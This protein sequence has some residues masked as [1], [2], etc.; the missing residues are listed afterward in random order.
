[1]S[2]VF[3]VKTSGD[4]LK[5][6]QNLDLSLRKAV[7]MGM[8]TESNALKEALREDTLAGGLGARFGKTWQNKDRAG[9]ILVF[10]SRPGVYSMSAAT[11]VYSKAPKLARAFDEGTVIR[12]KKG[13]G[14][15]VL[16]IPTKDVPKSGKGGRR[17]TPLEYQV[18]F[19]W[20]TLEPVFRDGKPVALV[21]QNAR[22]SYSA[23]TKAF[24]GFRFYDQGKK[25][26]QRQASVILYTLVPA[27]RLK[28]RLH[29]ETT[30]RRIAR[31]LPY[32]IRNIRRSL[33]RG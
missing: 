29:I 12:V 31:R 8:R 1:M 22:A 3:S 18:R 30:F 16:A 10:P 7:T 32:T 27:A 14:R 5:K 15:S 26:V 23:K 25:K 20:D 2:L 6:M 19:G 17:L 11:T 4:F 24:R 21:A 9:R 13:G 33:L 28:K